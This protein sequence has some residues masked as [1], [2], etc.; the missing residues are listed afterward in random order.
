MAI[1]YKSLIKSRETRLRLLKLLDFL[2]DKTVVRL[3]YRIKT[4][5]R[6]N[7]NSPT[8]FSEKLQWYKLYYRDMLMSMCA[9]KYSVREYVTECGYEG[10]L[11]PIIGIYNSVD[12][13]DF[14]KLP[15]QFVIKD[16]LGWGGTS[17]IIVTDK[18]EIDIDKTKRIV[19]NWIRP[20]RKN[21]GR[22]WV[23]EDRI[24]RVLIDTY[25][26]S[27]PDNGGLIDYKFFCFNGKVR[28]IYIIG[29]RTIGNGAELAIYDRDYNRVPYL[30]A[31][32][33][34]LRLD[35]KKPRNYQEMIACAE[36]LAKPF[37]HARI[38]LYDQNEKIIFGEIT[39]FDGSGYMKFDPDEFDEI[40]GKEFILPNRNH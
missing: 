21:P 15:N 2:P 14:E 28:Y 3:Q 16:T 8:R 6:L 33:R 36:K 19:A 22:E 39:F 20:R 25:I 18:E 34:P 12:E 37:P 17:V 29:D 7:L 31:D 9:D 26:P 30:R 40:M 24:N 1:D 10:I 23:Y 4:G 11:N 38:D 5:R 32:E 27:D 13:I 35:I